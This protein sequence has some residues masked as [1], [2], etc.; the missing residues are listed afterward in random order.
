MFW[1]LLRFQF[2]RT[3]RSSTLATR[4]ASTGI[5]VLF[6]YLPLGGLL[7][8]T[9]LGLPYVLREQG[10]DPVTAA[11]S[12]ILPALLCA[13]P[14]VA[15]FHRRIQAPLPALL[16][17][18]IRR[19]K[20][21]TAL[22]VM[23]AVNVSMGVTTV[24]LV[25][26][27]STGILPRVDPVP[28]IVWLIGALAVVAGFHGVCQVLR[29]TLHRSV[30]AFG[31]AGVA[32]IAG[33][34]ADSF[35]GAAWVSAWSTWLFSGVRELDVVAI[36]TLM[37]GVGVLFTA[38]KR[39]M[40]HTL[41]LDRLLGDSHTRRASRDGLRTLGPLARTDLRLLL[42]NSRMRVLALQCILMGGAAAIYAALS[43]KPD[44]EFQL[45]VA[46]FWAS[47]TSLNYLQVSQRA[48]K[49]FT[50]GL[51]ARPIPF[52]QLSQSVLGIADL[53]TAVTAVIA[54]VTAAFL[55]PAGYVILLGATFVYVAGIVNGTCA[56]VSVVIRA[57]Y[58]PD[59][60]MFSLQGSAG[61][62][63]FLPVLAMNLGC[64]APVAAALLLVPNPTVW[65]VPAGIAAVGATG[66]AARPILL[67]YLAS[68]HKR[69]RH[70]L[71]EHYREG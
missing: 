21:A 49:N 33:T 13:A 9:G 22:V 28:A 18:P 46:A 37:A 62:S 45:A 38:A 36:I 11:E 58:N 53:L 29:L 2:V 66:L 40:S 57:P 55:V 42:R 15:Y 69:R 5:A 25:A 67:S 27:G 10:I 52:R 12:V 70:T 60:G 61:G 23:N 35:V 24:L 20:L 43:L 71:M 3:Y 51:A 65:Y 30:A 34:L 41:Y 47:A 31:A 44:Q 48:R 32:L 68:F 4:I 16:S 26:Y 1:S 19:A 6:A 50:D 59:G 14:F 64:V 17:R 7:L 56:V 63:Q 39:W 54:L 8:L